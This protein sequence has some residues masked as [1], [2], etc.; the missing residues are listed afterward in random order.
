MGR[1]CV[2][3]ASAVSIDA[4]AHVCGSE[5]VNSRKAIITLDGATGQVLAGHVPTI[6][7]ELVGDFGTLMGWADR[8]RA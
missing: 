4:N 5:R 6:E 7:P 3:G 8:H 1:P 2:S